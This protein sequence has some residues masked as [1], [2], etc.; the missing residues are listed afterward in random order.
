MTDQ[1]F[2][3]LPK[4]VRQFVLRRVRTTIRRRCVNRG[5]GKLLG[6]KMMH[7]LNGNTTDYVK[8][9]QSFDE[10]LKT[11]NDKSRQQRVDMNI[12]VSVDMPKTFSLTHD[13]AAMAFVAVLDGFMYHI[14]FDYLKKG[15]A[16]RIIVEMPHPVNGCTKQCGWDDNVVRSYPAPLLINDIIPI[17]L[18][19]E[20]T[21]GR[22][23]LQKHFITDDDYADFDIPLDDSLSNLQY[24]SDTKSWNS[25]GSPAQST[26]SNVSGVTAP[27]S[28]TPTPS[29]SAPPPKSNKQ[30]SI[31]RRSDS[32]VQT[33]S[34]EQRVC[35]VP[36]LQPTPSQPTPPPTLAAPRVVSEGYTEPHTRLHF[37]ARHAAQISEV[38]RPQLPDFTEN[39]YRKWVAEVLL[40]DRNNP[41]M[42]FPLLDLRSPL[43]IWMS[44]GSFKTVM[45]KHIQYGNSMGLDAEMLVHLVRLIT[46]KREASSFATLYHKAYTWASHNREDWPLGL[47][48]AQSAGCARYTLGTSS[49]YASLLNNITPGVSEESFDVDPQINP[50]YATKNRRNFVYNVVLII[51]FIL[52]SYAAYHTF[53]F[54]RYVDGHY[55]R[56]AA[57]A[58]NSFENFGNQFTAFAAVTYGSSCFTHERI[59]CALGDNDCYRRNCRDLL[60]IYHP[61]K[62]G[63]VDSYTH[64]A[65]DC[66]F[67]NKGGEQPVYENCAYANKEEGVSFELN[68]LYVR[69][70]Q[71]A[72]TRGIDADFGDYDYFFQAAPSSN[73]ICDAVKNGES[74]P[75]EV[76]MICQFFKLRDFR[77]S[78]YNYSSFFNAYGSMYHNGIIFQSIFPTM[79][80]ICVSF[81]KGQTMR[82]HM[83]T[84][85]YYT[86]AFQYCCVCCFVALISVLFATL[87]IYPTVKKA[88]IERGFRVGCSVWVSKCS[89]TGVTSAAIM[90]TFI[91]IKERDL[92]CRASSAAYVARALKEL[93]L[94]VISGLRSLWAAAAA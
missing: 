41:N 58:D 38:E 44:S 68:E 33:P 36:P 57:Y 13:L 62:G 79:V 56:F 27:S 8:W 76:L 15:K 54:A 91:L 80:S 45:R 70:S 69:F 25:A 51:L 60:R 29:T 72:K 35:V 94:L 16:K 6:N 21:F 81:G 71:F 90:A 3:M 24:D 84:E 17:P 20:V 37:L 82:E 63:N 74:V 9:K 88:F 59:G 86:M 77:P 49:L 73:P 55:N 11:T 30:L 50:V 40:G 48:D 53:R 32:K 1:Q 31:V 92:L 22:N 2:H 93:L 52:F 47:S 19:C 87:A 66:E 46:E 78:C 42:Q 64:V 83:F 43:A 26:S 14:A 85:V 5:R 10:S 61:D 39:P 34:V 4:L 65:R 12:R 18:P 28:S 89:V 75:K 23:G 7:A 67:L